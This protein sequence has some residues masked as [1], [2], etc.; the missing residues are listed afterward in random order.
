MQLEYR[1]SGD[2]WTE[3][4]L[5]DLTGQASVIRKSSGISC[6]STFSSVWSQEYSYQNRLAALVEM[7]SPVPTS[8]LQG[9]KSQGMPRN[10]HSF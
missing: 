10:E 4:W 3:K 8:R 5:S 1:V 9:I 6:E 7:Q 2:E